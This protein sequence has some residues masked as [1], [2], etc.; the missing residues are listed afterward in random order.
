[1]KFPKDILPSVA[2][3]E[4]PLFTATLRDNI[5]YGRPDASIADV[6]RALDRAGL[7]DFLRSL[8]AWRARLVREPRWT[9]RFPH[10]APDQRV[11][12]W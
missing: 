9:C 1:M 2:L 7:R 4:N 10:L 8:P 3:Q 12:I 11:K 6:M 5:A